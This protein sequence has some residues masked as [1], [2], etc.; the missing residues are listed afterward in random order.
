MSRTKKT[1]TR[2][3][4]AAVR[5]IPKGKSLTYREVAKHAGS[6]RAFRAVG[7]IL[8][9][10]YDLRVP[11]HRVVRSDKVVGGYNLGTLE[12]IRKLTAEGVRIVNGKIV[13]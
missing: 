4:L 6:P 7:S 5:N 1:F 13:Y 8:K 3:V 9:T 10:N 2:K 12:K 11:C